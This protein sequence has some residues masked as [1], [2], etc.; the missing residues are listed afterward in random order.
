MLFIYIYL[1]V[2]ITYLFILNIELVKFLFFDCLYSLALKDG[3]NIENLC[4]CGWL[5]IKTP[6][7]YCVTHSQCYNNNNC[8]CI[9]FFLK[10]TLK[11]MSY[12][13]VVLNKHISFNG[14]QCKNVRKQLHGLVSSTI[15]WKAHNLLIDYKHVPWR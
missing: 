9:I 1:L 3:I 13:G 14:G 15:W 7:D 10:A 2:Y 8:G 5:V 6:N 12:Y 4:I 11:Q